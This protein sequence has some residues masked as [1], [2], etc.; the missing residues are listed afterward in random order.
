MR[1]RREVLT[2]LIYLAFCLEG[3]FRYEKQALDLKRN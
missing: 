2:N 3:V 1:R